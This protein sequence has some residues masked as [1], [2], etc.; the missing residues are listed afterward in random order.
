[1]ITGPDS[2]TL[3][4]KVPWSLS[5]SWE[6]QRGINELIPGEETTSKMS[7]VSSASQGRLRD[8]LGPPG[9]LPA[10]LLHVTNFPFQPMV[11]R[12]SLTVEPSGDTHGGKQSKACSHPHGVDCLSVTPRSFAPAASHA[13]SPVYLR[14]V[15]PWCEMPTPPP[16]GMNPSTHPAQLTGCSLLVASKVAKSNISPLQAPWPFI[17]PACSPVGPGLVSPSSSPANSPGVRAGL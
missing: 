11:T 4:W 1:M 9:L 5:H 8:A 15:L 10:F 2:R 17:S 16:L 6:K 14:S 7:L 3:I 12:S 13:V